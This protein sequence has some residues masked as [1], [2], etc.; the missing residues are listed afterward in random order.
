MD[1]KKAKRIYNIIF[2]VLSI[3]LFIFLMS[4]F[5]P[6][7]HAPADDIWGTK[8]DWLISGFLIFVLFIAGVGIYQ[9]AAY[10]L[11]EPRCGIGKTFWNVGKLLSSLIVG[12]VIVAMCVLLQ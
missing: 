12:I 9:S 2:F 1:T 6:S 5:E 7:S 10:F 11:F 3:A 4:L 8:Y